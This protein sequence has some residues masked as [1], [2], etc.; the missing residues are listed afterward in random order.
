MS[1]STIIHNQWTYPGEGGSMIVPSDS[2]YRHLRDLL[3]ETFEHYSKPLFVAE[4][5]IED[6]TRRAWLRYV[7][8]EVFAAIA[9]SVPVLGV[10]LYPLV[11]HPGWDDDRHCYN[12]LFDYGNQNRG[13]REAF[14]P[15]ANELARQQRFAELILAGNL[16]LLIAVR[17]MF[18]RSI[19]PRMRWRRAPMRA[20]Q[21]RRRH[22]NYPYFA[23]ISTL[24]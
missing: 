18:R 2:R 22:C 17:P 3:Q 5:G 10:C 19:G 7:C 13:N 1:A 14:E 21:R 6:G 23:W 15:L 11:N 20:A 9:N 16:F 12:G 4:T 8:N 24:C